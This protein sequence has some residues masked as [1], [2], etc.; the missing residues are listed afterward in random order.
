MDVPQAE[1]QWLPG[2]QLSVSSFSGLFSSPLPV[3]SPA[4]IVIPPIAH[5]HV[6]KPFNYHTLIPRDL[7]FSVR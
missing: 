1:P 5:I 4:I 7:A 2:L 3:P 6:P